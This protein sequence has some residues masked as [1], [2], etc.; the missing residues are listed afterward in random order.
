ME[1][2]PG[3]VIQLHS[4]LGGDIVSQAQRGFNGLAPLTTEL[5]SHSR[6]M[7][8]GTTCKKPVCALIVTR[9]R[10]AT[11]RLDATGT[12]CLTGATRS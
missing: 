3:V 12:A 9:Q 10:G 2:G 7:N 1:K 8:T 6:A 4:E 5:Q 11:R